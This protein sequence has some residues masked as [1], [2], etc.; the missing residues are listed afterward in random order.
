M[1]TYIIDTNAILRL[2]LDDIPEQY[3]VVFDVFSKAEKNQIKVILPIQIIFELE[4]VLDKIYKFSKF[5]RYELLTSFLLTK[6][7]NLEHEEFRELFIKVLTIFRNKNISLVD[8][9][10]LV[11]AKE[12]K[13]KILTFDKNLLKLENTNI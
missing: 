8:A 13:A 6:Y 10:I 2:I 4:Y 11:L 3:S 12:N 9:Y 1:K 7:I 5:E